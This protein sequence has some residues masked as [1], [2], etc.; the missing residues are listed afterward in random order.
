ML[1]VVSREDD[2]RARCGNAAQ[3]LSTLGRIA[4]NLLKIET[5][6]PKEPIRGKRIYAVPEPS[7]L[8]AIIGLRQ[9]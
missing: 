5:A 7:Y 4:L 2:A 3:N 6:K 8:K 1:D 9:M